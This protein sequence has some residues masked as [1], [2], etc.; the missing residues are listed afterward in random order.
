MCFISIREH[1][2]SLNYNIT[3][4]ELKTVTADQ[5]TNTD[6]NK[7]SGKGCLCKYSV[8]L[9]LLLHA[10]ILIACLSKL[11][12]KLIHA[13]CEIVPKVDFHTPFL[14]L[15]TKFNSEQLI[16]NTY[17]IYTVYNLNNV[18]NHRLYF[19]NLQT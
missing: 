2:P 12:L 18:L 16:I 7:S 9:Q 11:I 6:R 3:V 1:D 17:N 15:N 19:C 5:P 14:H 10:S 4:N 13:L 8:T